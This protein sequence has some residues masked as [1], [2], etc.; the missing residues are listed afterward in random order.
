MSKVRRSRSLEQNVKIVSAHIYVKSGLIYPSSQELRPKWFIHTLYIPGAAAPG[1][2]LMKM[3]KIVLLSS[4][5]AIG[6]GGH[7][8][9]K[10]SIWRF[11]NFSRWFLKEFMHGASTASWERLFHLFM[12]RWE[13]KWW[14]ISDWWCDFVNFQLMCPRVLLVIVVRLKNCVQE[15]A[16]KPFTILKSSIRS[17]LFFERP[18][19]QPTESFLVWQLF[20]I[21]EHPGKSMLDSFQQNFVFNMM[22][23]PGCWAVF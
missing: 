8:S 12:L 15:R 13:K 20:Q 18:Q 16:E 11:R 9:K 21:T 7:Q 17:A 1:Y 2:L 5:A 22:R 4:R 14:R 10:K 6:L 3:M 19:S 23:T